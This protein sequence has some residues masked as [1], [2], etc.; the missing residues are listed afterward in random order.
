[1]IMYILHMYYIKRDVAID[2]LTL[3]E[4]GWKFRGT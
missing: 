4:V 2:K 1:M 3:F